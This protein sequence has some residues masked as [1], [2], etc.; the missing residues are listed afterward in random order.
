MTPQYVEL[1]MA[2]GDHSTFPKASPEDLSDYTTAP[3]RACGAVI[4]RPSI[5]DSDAGIGQ[6][7]WHC[8]R[9]G[10]H[11]GLHIAIDANHKALCAKWADTFVIREED[12]L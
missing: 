1:I 7:R 6:H 11:D 12:E 2:E 10:G 3:N 9:P 4:G 5:R 8:T